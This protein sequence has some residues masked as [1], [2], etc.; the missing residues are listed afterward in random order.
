ML[1][2]I[3]PLVHTKLMT[4]VTISPTEALLMALGKNKLFSI[5]GKEKGGGE[6]VGVK[7]NRK[8]R[9]EGEMGR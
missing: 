5:M 3:F 6:E 9:G 8:C 4:L 7:E 1:L 2:C